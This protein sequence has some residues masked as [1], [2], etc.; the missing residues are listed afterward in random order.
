MTGELASTAHRYRRWRGTLNQGR[1]TWL[2]IVMT[3]IRLA[4]KGMRTRTLLLSAS[5]VVLGGTIVLYLLSL[6]EVMAGTRE[7]AG[8]MEFV[9]ALL[10]VDIS[11]AA[12]IGDYREILWNL[13]F[14]LTV[15]AQ[16]FWVLLVVSA[17]GPGLIANDLKNGALPIYFAKP[18]TP[19]TYL[20]GKWAVAASFIA[21]VTVVPNL[22]TLGLGTL[23][24]GGL[25]TWGQT[26]DLA[27]GVALSGVT[28]CMVG[29]AIILALSSLSSDHRYVTVA[30]LALCLL[31]GIAQGIINELLPPAST[32]GWLGCVSLRDNV[33]TLTDWLFGVREA[34]EAASLPTE[35]FTRALVK[36]VSVPQATIVLAAWTVGGLLISYRRVVSFSRSAANL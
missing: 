20:C 30:W 25:H 36:S 33:V 24:A 23:I 8:M 7:A 22:L 35:A 10:R 34:I 32:T 15:K 6:L 29:G 14:L 1:W 19:L 17:F 3:G 16:M 18:I 27:M 5:A 2:P 21:M 26:L 11:G 9:S 4:L 13:L 12:R 28:L 31:P